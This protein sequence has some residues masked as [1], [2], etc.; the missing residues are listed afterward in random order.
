MLQLKFIPFFL[1]RDSWNAYF[2]QPV[3]SSAAPLINDPPPA[4]WSKLTFGSELK[5]V[6]LQCEI[7]LLLEY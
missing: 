6:K 7:C 3:I 2:I 4:F 1:Q 5:Q